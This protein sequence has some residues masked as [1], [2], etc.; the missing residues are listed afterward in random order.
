M[1][2]PSFKNSYS[3]S[4]QSTPKSKRKATRVQ[5]ACFNCRKRKQGCDSVRPCKRCVEKG[6]PCVE[7]ESKRRRGR[8]KKEDSLK[9]TTKLSSSS[10]SSSSRT[11][12]AAG[13]EISESSHTSQSDESSSSEDENSSFEEEDCEMKNCHSSSYKILKGKDYSIEKDREYDSPNPNG[14]QSNDYQNA[15]LK[16]SLLKPGNLAFSITSNVNSL[17]ASPMLTNSHE[18]VGVTNI[19]KSDLVAI[20]LGLLS[21]L[22]ENFAMSCDTFLGNFSDQQT[23]PSIT[24]SNSLTF[25]LED[26]GIGSGQNY[27]FLGNLNLGNNICEIQYLDTAF[28]NFPLASSNPEHCSIDFCY[29]LLSKKLTNNECAQKLNLRIKFIWKEILIAL[30][31]LDWKKAQ[32][33]LEELDS[34]PSLRLNSDFVFRQSPAVVM[35]SPGGRIHFANDS[36]SLISGYSSDELKAT[37]SSTTSTTITSA[38]SSSKSSSNNPNSSFYNIESA[39]V[40]ANQ[41]FDS[42]EIAKILAKQLE[43]IQG[44]RSSASSFLMKTK[45]LT[46]SKREVPIHCSLNH[47]KDSFGFLILTTMIILS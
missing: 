41:L 4:N 8:T 47:L 22:L 27:E 40:N 17:G 2:A 14:T 30:R 25:P 9:N 42:S 39:K 36:F 45:L 7:V 20:N 10:N 19:E 28:G 3:P 6:I 46:K 1:F 21:P 15:S 38:S 31:N 18:E 35:W 16:D 32:C 5:W 33:L 34:S 44:S 26:L 11:S 13:M 23:Q 43:A 12:G 29:K 37:N 24:T